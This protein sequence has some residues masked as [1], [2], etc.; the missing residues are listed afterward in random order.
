EDLWCTLYPEL[1]KPRPGLRGQ[2]LARGA[3]HVMR[4]ESVFALLD[5]QGAVDV[6]HLAAAAAWW[7]Y[8][9]ESVDVI[10]AGR[11]GD[12]AADRIRLEMLPGQRLSL[13][14]IREQIFGGHISAGRL[15]NALE[16][17]EKLGEVRIEPETTA[18]RPRTMVVRLDDARPQRADEL[19]AGA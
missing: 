17:L 10:F 14:D 9:A 8:C 16:L 12:D 2:L 7:D 13:T 3:P 19:D 6:S 11:T 5:L 18:G 4:L 15:R 1:K